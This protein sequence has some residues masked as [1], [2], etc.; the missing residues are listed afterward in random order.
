MSDDVRI[1]TRAS[2][3]ARTQTGHIASR[4]EEL[5]YSTVI[6]H[7]RTAGDDPTLELHKA[8]QPGVFVSALRDALL[9]KEVDVIVHSLKDL[10]SGE[11][12]GV[13]LAAVPERED[14]RDVLIGRAPLLELPAGAVVGTSSPRRSAFILRERPDLIVRPI[15][16]NIDTRIVKARDGEY[17]AVILAMAGLRRIGR[18]DEVVEAFDITRCIPAPSQGA[19]AVECR[20]SDEESAQLLWPLDDAETRWDVS[21][22]RAVLSAISA[23]CATAIGAHVHGDVL[24]AELSTESAYVRTQIDCSQFGFGHDAGRAAA[25]RLLA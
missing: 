20:A 21:A 22:E 10:P 17:D 14:P 2:L 9:R 5:G 12:P 1:G 24:Y 25:E 6:T 15:R 23:S 3:L 11:C 19:L 7:I 16:G 4:I 8:P 18:E 13:V